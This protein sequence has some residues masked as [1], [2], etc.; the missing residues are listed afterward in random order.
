MT[1]S[2]ANG[3]RSAQEVW[4][5]A[6]R[7]FAAG[8][9]A[10]QW[11]SENL[12]RMF[13]GN[14]V[15]DLD[16]NF[17]GKRVLD[18]GCG[19][20]NNLRFLGSLGLELFGCEIESSILDLAR[21]GLQPLE[22]DPHLAVG[23][24]RSIPFAPDFF[25]FLVS[26]NVIHYE[27]NENDLRQGLAEYARVLKPGGRLFLST[28]GPD[29]LILKNARKL[30]PHRYRIE[31]PGE[32]RVGQIY[33]YFEDETTIERLFSEHFDDVRV[34]RARDFLFT[35]YQ[36]YFLVTAKARSEKALRNPPPP[37]R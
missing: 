30:E 1:P 9:A 33:Y 18:M 16:K 7:D 11:P 13:K 5:Q 10:L 15:P 28:T 3:A 34:G 2:S 31:R 36:D 22:L 20:G 24:N 8:G 29:H 32:F 6:Y 25:D 4:T 19:A 27:S 26:W 37:C 23:S 21:E 35:E 17:S 12:V 14:Y